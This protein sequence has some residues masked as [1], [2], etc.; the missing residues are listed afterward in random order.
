MSGARTMKISVLVQPDGMIAPKPALRDRRAGV[1]ADERV[2]R[3][4]RQAEVPGDQVPDDRAE[5]AAEDH[6]ER[7][8]VEVD[9]PLADR[10]RHGGAE[11][12]GG[13]EVEERRPDH[14]LPGESTRVETT[15]AIEFAAS[16]KPL[17]KSN[18]RARRR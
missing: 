13:D 12:E 8:D 15:V 2:R 6:A 3:A 7:D 11:R 4:G 17:M 9:H 14:R 16:W 10:L 5:Q 1:A 18:D